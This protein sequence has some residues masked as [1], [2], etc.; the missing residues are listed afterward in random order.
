MN[1][2]IAKIE[3]LGYTFSPGTLILIA[4]IVEAFTVGVS[5]LYLLHLPFA[6]ALMVLGILVVPS[7]YYS[8][9]RYKYEENRFSA[10]CTYME[11]MCY[12]FQTM[13]K[14][15]NALKETYTILPSGEMKAAVSA[16]I[17]YFEVENGTYADALNIIESRFLCKKLAKLHRFFIKIEEE[18]GDYKYAL[19]LLLTDILKWR[20]RVQLYQQ[21]KKTLKVAYVLAIIFSSIACAFATLLAVVGK[22]EGDLLTTFLDITGVP[23]YQMIAFVFIAAC[24]ISFYFIEKRYTNSWIEDK[25]YTK[26]ELIDYDISI[27]YD[28]ISDTRRMLIRAVVIAGGSVILSLLFT[29]L[30]LIGLILAILLIATPRIKYQGARQRT[31]SELKAA[32]SEWLVDLELNLQFYNNHKA[33]E[34]SLDSAPEILKKPIKQL[35]LDINDNLSGI[36]PFNN[37][38]GEFDIEEVRSSMRMVYSMKDLNSENTSELLSTIVDRNYVLMDQTEAEKN[39]TKI[40]NLKMLILTPAGFGIFKLSADLMIFAATFFNGMSDVSQFM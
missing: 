24:I 40:S 32:F 16:A 6:I 4:V 10:L 15:Y 30:C 20:E 38:L 2:F 11:Q 28:Y 17:K 7:V 13:P 26:Y 33:I 18:G 29:P 36:E 19:G 31:V 23:V 35:I 34:K 14:I 9:T 27:N 12:S 39:K 37:F 22:K 3:S 25:K 21:E 1:K 5:F 8:R